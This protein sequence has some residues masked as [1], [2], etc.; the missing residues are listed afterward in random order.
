[1]NLLDIIGRT[2]ALLE[3]DIESNEKPLVSYLKI[4]RS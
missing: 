4:L 2:R 1:M 3:Q